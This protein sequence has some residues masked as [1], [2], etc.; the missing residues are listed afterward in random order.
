MKSSE[1]FLALAKFEINFPE[2]SDKNKKEVIS[3][4]MERK[5][6]DGNIKFAISGYINSIKKLIDRNYD[7]E[8]DG[9][10]QEKLKFAKYL[11]E[12]IED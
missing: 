11:Q 5:E 6:K 4:I 3:S 8:L 10:Y 1:L 7:E 12:I 2:C 9:I